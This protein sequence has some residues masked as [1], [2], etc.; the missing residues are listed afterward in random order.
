[1]VQE[2]LKPVVNYIPRY[3]LFDKNGTLVEAST[4]HPSDGEKLHQQLR[5]RLQLR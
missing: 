2:S 4:Y 1:M 5:E 3:M